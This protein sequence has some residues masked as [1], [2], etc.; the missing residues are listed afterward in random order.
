MLGSSTLLQASDRQHL[1]LLYEDEALRNETEIDCINE[2]L[3][4]GQ[5]CIFASVDVQEESF[6][7]RLAARIHDYDRHVKEGNLLI[8]NFMPFYSSAAKSDL[9]LFKKL[10][11]QIELSINDRVAS[12]KNPK[13]LVVADAACNLTKQKQFTECVSLEG[14][15]QQT[16]VE[17]V[18]SNL[19][20]TIICAHPTTILQDKHL[21]QKSHIS[22]VHSLTIDLAEFSKPVTK[23]QTRTHER[24]DVKPIR[25]LIAE[26]EPDI[27]SVYKRYFLSLPVETLI[28]GD[29]KDCLVQA[30]MSGD[31]DVV[32]IDTHLKDFDGIEIARKILEEKPEQ[33]VVLTTTQDPDMILSRLGSEALDANATAVL[34]KPFK[35]SELLSVLRPSER[36][37]TSN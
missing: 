9:A 25:V 19:D 11:E 34:V 33:R 7:T 13:T 22:D 29:A 6:M 27:Q 21:E 5:F 28:V 12:Q 31:F 35:F 15:W 26:R 30:L 10:K 37:L 4:L 14:W 18:R 2:G 3:K 1:M 24:S 20:I 17:W 36:R 16:Y 23:N 8:V 32:I